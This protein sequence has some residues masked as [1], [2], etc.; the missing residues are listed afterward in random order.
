MALH[1]GYMALTLMSLAMRIQS[2]MVMLLESSSG[3]Y[4]YTV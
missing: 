2:S 4:S 1:M 3:S